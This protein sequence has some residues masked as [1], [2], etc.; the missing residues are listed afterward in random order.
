M[1]A[2][3]SAFKL[4]S[5]SSIAFAEWLTERRLARVM[6]ST[7]HF[8][9]PFETVYGIESSQLEVTLNDLPLSLEEAFA[10]CLRDEQDTDVYRVYAC[11][12]REELKV[13]E[14]K[15]IPSEV[16]S[17]VGILQQKNKTLE[18]D[19]Y[20]PER[21]R[22]KPDGPNSL[23]SAEAVSLLKMSDVR[24][25]DFVVPPVH[26]HIRSKAK[27]WEEFK[28]IQCLTD[29]NFIARVF[30]SEPDS[31]SPSELPAAVLSSGITS[32]I[33]DFSVIHSL[34]DLCHKLQQRGPKTYQTVTEEQKKESDT[35]TPLRFTCEDGTDA[36]VLLTRADMRLPSF[37]TI[38]RLTH[39]RT[40]VVAVVHESVVTFFM[41]SSGMKW[42]ELPSLWLECTA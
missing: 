8:L 10:I 38:K 41:F 27:T 33:N 4:K 28:E 21:K 1:F 35:F 34:P 17:S 9:T 26:Q 37:Q 5:S 3:I 30:K 11:L 15:D 2:K 42:Q 31:F 12:R 6:Q 25:R 32:C 39:N 24:H 22:Y 40:L 23:M 19:R 18:E 20:S 16:E 13:W 7:D 14:T 29:Q 36:T